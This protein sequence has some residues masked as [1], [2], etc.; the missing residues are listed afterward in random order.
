MSLENPSNAYTQNLTVS[1]V[2]LETG[3]RALVELLGDDATSNRV[4]GQTV[5]LELATEVLAQRIEAYLK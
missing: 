5:N 2:M 4:E 1:N 3:S